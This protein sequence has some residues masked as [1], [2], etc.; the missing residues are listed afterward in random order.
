MNRIALAGKLIARHLSRAGLVESA[1]GFTGETQCA[2]GSGQKDGISYANDVFISVFKQSGL[3][4]RLACR[5]NGEALLH[6]RKLPHWALHPA[7]TT[8]WDGSSN[9][10]NPTSTSARFSPIRRQQGDD[11]RPRTPATCCQDGPPAL[12]AA[13]FSYG[14]S[15]A[16]V[17][18]RS[19]G[20]HAFTLIPTWEEV[21][22]L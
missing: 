21:H 17:L 2:G 1:L 12:A 20:V 6:P 5:R 15:T 11:L 13:T 22:P 14:P 18:H 9:V 8:R 19:G 10:D 7:L 3:V 4:C 16:G